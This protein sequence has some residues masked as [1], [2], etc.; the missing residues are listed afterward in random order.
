MELREKLSELEHIQ[1]EHWSKTLADEIRKWR[2]ILLSKKKNG[3][4]IIIGLMQNRLT[5]WEQNWK[6]YKELPEDIKD[7]DREWADKVLKII[8][9]LE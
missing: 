6:E 2:S 4:I 9:N 1:W 8:N 7:Y 3:K 5:R